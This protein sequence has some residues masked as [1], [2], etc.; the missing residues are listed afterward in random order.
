MPRLNFCSVVIAAIDEE[1]LLHFS[2]TFWT[3]K[4]WVHKRIEA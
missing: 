3:L 2:Q 1:A 4:W